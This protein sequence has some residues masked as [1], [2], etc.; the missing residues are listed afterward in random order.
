MYRDAVV[1]PSDPDKLQ[2]LWD[3]GMRQ[4]VG[5]GFKTALDNAAALVY[6]TTVVNRLTTY[7][8][9]VS[10][11]MN[12]MLDGDDAKKT[13]ADPKACEQFL[14]DMHQALGIA[15]GLLK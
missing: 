1:D 9:L 13:A 5:Q 7:N 4:Y 15:T 8:T 10:K 12:K 6:S 11:W 14:N 3:Q 2:K